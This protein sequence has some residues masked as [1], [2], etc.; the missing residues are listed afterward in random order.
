MEPL[1]Q[2]IAI[3]LAKEIFRKHMIE[4]DGIGLKPSEMNYVL[5]V[6]GHKTLSYDDFGELQTF[7]FMMKER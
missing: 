1:R 7:D 3:D 2:E 6:A 5:L 4:G